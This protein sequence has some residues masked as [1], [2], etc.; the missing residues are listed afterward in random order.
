MM[1]ESIGIVSI[2]INVLVIGYA[3]TRKYRTWSQKRDFN[4]K[5][6]IQIVRR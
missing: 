2:M 6:N 4:K 5:Y 1:P 3:M